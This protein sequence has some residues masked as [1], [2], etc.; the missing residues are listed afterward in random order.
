MALLIIEEEENKKR[1]LLF[2]VL[3][4]FLYYAENKSKIF[5]LLYLG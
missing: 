1:M 3:Y 4:K 2:Q 5:L